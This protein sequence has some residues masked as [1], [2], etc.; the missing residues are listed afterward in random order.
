ME[1]ERDYI[2]FEDEDGSEIELDIIDVFEHASKYYAVL[3]DLSDIVDENGG[4]REDAPTAEE[5][6]MF[7][8]EIIPGEKEDEQEFI[9]VDNDEL[10]DELSEVVYARI[11]EASQPGNCEELS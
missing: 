7:I 6:E 9:P 11:F 3:M 10:L 5:K 1:E 4:V 2:V 8:M